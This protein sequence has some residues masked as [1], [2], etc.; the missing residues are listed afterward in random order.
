[1]RRERISENVYWFKS[2][3]YAQV[4]AG[5]VAGPLWAVVIDTLAMPEETL[6][7]RAFVE[8]DLQVPVRYVINTH[9]HADHCWGNCFFPGATLLA[10]SLC[11]QYMIDIEMDA[12]ETAK[13]QSPDFIQSKIKVP[14]LTL[15]TG[16]ISLRVGKK[17]LS[18][19]PTPGNSDD[20]ISVLIVEDRVL[21]AGDVFMPI[22]FIVEGDID[23]L[24]KSIDMIGKM[25]LENIVQGHGD[26]ILR[27][28]IQN[29]VKENL[30]YLSA[31]KR[32]VRIASRRKDPIKAIEKIDI[33]SCG[34]KRVI[35]GGLAEEL[36]KR[37]IFA[38]HQHL[39]SKDN[40]F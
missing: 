29:A 34:K 40:G 18:I 28:E 17:T 4:T 15:S 23:L 16:T 9:H 32:A 8:E 30:D 37:N 13:K 10:H 35:L 20:G 27:G 19:F 2:D 5:V 36:H 3:I 33:E 25:G 39:I 1:M 38:L 12:L 7:M 14:H 26:I 24:Y 31:V 21:F 6:M 22:P 11:R